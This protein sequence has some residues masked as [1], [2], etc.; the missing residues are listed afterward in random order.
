M[1]QKIDIAGKRFTNWMVTHESKY[2]RKATYWK[3][4]CDCGTISF[5]RQQH[6]RSGAS[7]SCGCIKKKVKIPIGFRFGSLTVLDNFERRNG[8]IYWSC[9]CE[10][11]QEK[12]VYSSSLIS[13]DV[14]TCGCGYMTNSNTGSVKKYY[15]SYINGAKKRDLQFSITVDDFIEIIQKDCH[16]CGSPP[17]KQKS[18]S[19]IQSIKCNGLDRVDNNLGYRLDNIVACCWKCNLMK[20]AMNENEFLSQIDKIY[21]KR[22]PK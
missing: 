19:K 20:S 11:G 22:N 10:C 2:D 17:V 18:L 6:L 21:L 4:V 13:G 8:K 7:P 5:V 3:C 16:Y 9:R 14:F 12:F 15:R 1:S